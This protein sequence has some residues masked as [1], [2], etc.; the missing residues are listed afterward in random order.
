MRLG[1]STK[2]LQ[3]DKAQSTIL[4]V[5]CVSTAVTIFSLISTKSLLSQAAYH[6]REVAAKKTALKQINDNVSAATNLVT[7]YQAFNNTNPNAIGGKNSQD[8]GV[9]PPDGTNSRVVLDALPSKYDFPALVSSV[10]NILATNNIVSPSVSGTDQSSTVSG[11]PTVVPQAI[12]IPMTISG[13]ASYASLQSL[14][15]DLERSI[16]PFDVTNLQ[17]RGS[18]DNI[19]FTLDST[20]YFQPPK[21][22]VVTNKE[23]K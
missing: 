10:S 17:I 1:F 9:K 13:T 7:Q 16:R 11:A 20:T 19:S 23:I 12:S 4:L 18:A 14:I 8:P 6:R 2:R 21:T 3:I 5:V 15:R 22:L